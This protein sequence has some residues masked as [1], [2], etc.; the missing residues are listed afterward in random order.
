MN[1]TERAQRIRH[2]SG[3]GRSDDSGVVLPVVILSMVT[4][5]IFAG[6]AIDYSYARQRDRRAQNNA[7]ASGLAAALEMQAAAGDGCTFAVAEGTGPCSTHDPRT[8]ARDY[9][10]W[11]RDD[12]IKERMYNEAVA[13][14][15][16]VALTW[17]KERARLRGF[18][19]RSLD[20]MGAHVGRPLRC[21]LRG[22]QVK[23]D[24]RPY[25]RVYEDLEGRIRGL[26]EMATQAGAPVPCLLAS[27]LKR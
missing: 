11:A 1:R 21:Q 27:P 13:I 19:T 4:L 18:L 9:L 17:L 24:G 8:V 15:A 5:L 16:D 14:V 25:F 6:I 12:F 22:I 7:D 20:L 26:R 23:N 2:E 3:V 10:I